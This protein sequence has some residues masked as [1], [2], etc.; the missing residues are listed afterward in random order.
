VNLRP[1]DL[2]NKFQ[3]CWIVKP[4]FKKVK[5]TTSLSYNIK[6]NKSLKE[7]H[8]LREM[9]APGTVIALEK[10]AA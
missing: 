8:A 2:P 6:I 10:E 4:S 3:A 7:E 1:A 5:K 9:F